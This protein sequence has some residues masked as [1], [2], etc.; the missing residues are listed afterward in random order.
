MTH[1]KKLQIIDFV[2]ENE[3]EIIKVEEPESKILHMFDAFL[4][5]VV[6]VFGKIVM[7]LLLLALLLGFAL[8][9]YVK[10]VISDIPVINPYEIQD[11]LLEHSVILDSKGEIIETLYGSSGLRST[12]EIEE[13]GPELKNALISIEDK[14]FY[15]HSGF[16]YIR[17]IGAVVQSL[18]TGDNIRG[19]STI[20]QQLAKNVYLTNERALT[21]K[22]K[23][24]YYAILLERTLEKDEILE[25]YMNRINFGMQANGVASASEIYFSKSA[26]EL[27]LV[28]SAMIAGIPKAPSRYA[29]MKRLLKK[30][31]KS[32]HTVIDD[33]DPLYTL[34]FNTES[35]NRYNVVIQQ[36]Y[37]NDLISKASYDYAYD[38]DISK[39]IT[40]SVNKTN[41]ISSYFADMVRADVIEALSVKENISF[42]EAEVLLFRKGYVIHSTIDFEM[43]K[44]LEHVYSEPILTTEFD[45]STMDAVKSFQS[46]YDLK[47][48]GV[49]GPST[50]EKLIELSLL[51]SEDFTVDRLTRWMDN[52]DVLKLQEGLYELGYLTNSRL[53][54]K[55][56][57]MFNDEKNI[58]NDETG[59][60]ILYKFDN[61]INDDNELLIGKDQYYFNNSDDLV[62]KRNGHLNFYQHPDKVQ[63]V[64]KQLFKYD[65]LSENRKVIDGDEFSVVSDLTI[66]EGRDLL[67]P[68]EYVEKVEGDVIVSK[69]F[70]QD[71]PT[72]FREDTEGNL[73]VNEKGYVVDLRGEI[74]PQSAFVIIDHNTSEIKA[75]V[76]GRESFGKKIFNRALVPHQPGSSVKPIGT[77]TVAIENGYTAASVVEDLPTYLNKD[78]P[79]ERWPINWYEDYYFKYRGRKNLRQGIE[80]SLNVVTAKLANRLG[81]PAIIEQ[82]QENGITTLVEED[83]NIAA[84]ALGG[85]TYGITPLELTNAYAT[86]ARQ[87]IY[88]EPISFTKLTDKAGNI[89][90]DNTPS[91]QRILD[92]KVA[93][94]IHDM[95]HSAVSVGYNKR[96]QIDENNK[97]VPVAGKTGTTSDQRDALFV[98]YTPYLTGGIWFGNDIRLKMNEGSKSASIFWSVAMK[99]IHEGYEDATFEEPEGIVHVYVDRVS[100]KLPSKLSYLDPAGSQVYEEIFIEGTE[101]TTVDD[102][103]VMVTICNDSGHLATPYCVNTSDVVRRVRLE[104][105]SYYIPVAD[106]G[107]MVPGTCQIPGHQKDAVR[108]HTEKVIQAFDGGEVRF[109]RNY[110]LLLK[111]GNLK[112]IPE[113]SV[114]SPN[115]YSITFPSGEVVSGSSYNIEYITKPETQVKA[116]TN[117]TNND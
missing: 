76:G 77:F 42:A 62:L 9:V 81:V 106:Q 57:V 72:F 84:V 27:N 23:E 14:T 98:G 102:S 46:D 12:V 40:P 82:L 4:H 2:P 87:G 34:V 94:I 117:R 41:E 64:V 55:V 88:S 37:D 48:D 8:S 28:E 78:T 110:N 74:Q 44:K 3:Q 90:I 65:E 52:N 43:Q 101:P 59:H 7:C 21:R 16:N 47:I 11:G 109:I 22:I 89:I 71:N 93:F 1:Y 95:L 6:N 75:I 68:T 114:V 107:Y 112:F 56:V 5:F 108:F 79:G 45:E 33:S 96:A 111:N 17:L 25:A 73:W 10:S 100:G 26:S 32:E 80:Q 85:M 51:S 20:T 15:E 66:H 58:V 30:D 60:V 24:A 92:E 83:R 86:Y 54:P 39:F 115:D 53:F 91:S 61:L 116:L 49:A 18:E 70:I 36:M 69:T 105:Y 13:I 67:I 99:E 29:P 113:N 97:G 63:I 38:I 103:H 50:L 35:Q 104:P 31:V 19:T